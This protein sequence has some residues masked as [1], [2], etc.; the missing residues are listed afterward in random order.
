MLFNFSQFWLQI[1]HLFTPI[2]GSL[3]IDWP[4]TRWARAFGWLSQDAL[5]VASGTTLSLNHRSSAI[6]TVLCPSSP[7]VHGVLLSRFARFL[8][9][10]VVFYYIFSFCCHKSGI[11]NAPIFCSSIK[12]Q[13]FSYDFM[14]IL[15][16]ILY[17]CSNAYGS[18]TN[19][20]LCINLCFVFLRYD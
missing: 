8:L 7:G 9:Q 6:R 17:W 16:F 13:I 14:C 10:F 15:C 5:R 20:Y 11:W 19:V 1:E 4:V 12:G 2:L 3:P 18:D